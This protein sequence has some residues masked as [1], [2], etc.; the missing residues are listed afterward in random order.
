MFYRMK[1]A[2]L[3]CALILI[4]GCM[5]AGQAP[6]AGQGPTARTVENP[7]QQVTQTELP[8]ATG[9]ARAE[10]QPAAR[11]TQAAVTPTRT[12][13]TAT[14]HASATPGVGESLTADLLAWGN[15]VEDVIRLISPGDGSQVVSPLVVAFE[16]ASPRAER[17]W[18]ELYGVDGRL[19]ARH[20]LRRE[21]EEGEAQ[22]V[23]RVI[24]YD[25]RLASEQARVVVSLKDET[26][27]PAAVTSAGVVL[28]ASGP[29]KLVEA[30]T[31]PAIQLQS[32]R[33]GEQVETG[34]LSVS[35]L[36]H[37]PVSEPL[38]VQ[39][40]AEDGNLIGQR[41]AGVSSEGEETYGTF[42]AEL[43]YYVV[44]PTPAWLVIYQDGKPFG[45]VAQLIRVPVMLA[46]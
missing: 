27:R 25:I 15:G 37:Q 46:P 5:P 18:V 32:P 14:V 28:Q 21:G 8:G 41:L 39:L 36:V 23:E 42:T 33:S 7:Q 1:V 12:L 29:A 24:P 3:V 22:R 38:R 16:Y 4:S 35:G 9:T 19:L 45:D 34:R 43:E 26:G 17:V 31:Q 13:Q 44:R 30:W 2:W 20:I 10:T 11:R 6:A 40:L